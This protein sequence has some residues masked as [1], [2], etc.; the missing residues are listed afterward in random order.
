[1][2]DTKGVQGASP[3][4]AVAAVDA[5]VGA[6]LAEHVNAGARVALAL[7]GGIDSMVL[8]DVLTPLV[9]SYPL[10]LSAIHVHHGLSPNADRW[11]HFC[12]EQCALRNIPLTVH[13]LRL[14]VR[15]GQS[16][17][18]PAR[19]AR[20]EC[21]MAADADVVA[22]A[23]HA[24]D[25]AETVLLQLLRG[26]GPRG[27]SAM[28]GFR[29]GQPSLWRPLLSL[30]RQK[31]HDYARLRDLTWIEDES[32]VDQKH[33]RNLL[34][35]AVAPLLSASFPGYPGTLVR[36]AA[37]Q[38]EA[39]ALLDELAALDA[40]GAVDELG[41]DRL[42]LAA[43]PTARAGNLLRWFMRR[44]GLR[45]PSQARLSEMLRQLVLTANDA[46]VSIA[47]EGREIGVHRGRI[48]VHVRQ[49][50]PYVLA[51]HGEREV[52]LPWGALTFVPI[53]GAGLCADKLKQSPV[54][55]RSRTGGE[56]IQL[57]TNRP[58]HAVKKLLQQAGL[59]RWERDALPLVWCGNE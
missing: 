36:A 24:D 6:A 15:P 20:Y 35:H 53:H 4:N 49:P 5:V 42:S 33:K 21:L 41:L 55:L 16:I 14:E 27:V 11:A 10:L 17:E 46:K 29:E 44:E 18:A 43:L 48:L 12:A 31:L 37:H 9:A 3:A 25:Q 32:N 56:R 59:A 57:A 23:H 30:S 50:E 45:P 38:A 47:H 26:A 13:R 2:S 22:L 39:S 58:H 52:R 40:A 54:S 8:L 28:P 19:T 34:R 1:M 51:W 7:S